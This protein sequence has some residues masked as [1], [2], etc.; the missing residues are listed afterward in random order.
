MPSEKR[1]EQDI[2]LAL[3]KQGTIMFKN[4][5]GTAYRGKLLLTNGKRTLTNPA[6]IRYGLGGIKG[7]SDQIGITP[8]VITSDMIGETI[9]VFT[10]IEV[11]KDKNGKYKATKEQSAFIAMVKANGGIAGVCDS[12]EDSIELIVEQFQF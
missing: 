8:V 4:N 5:V 6:I 7:G 12:V 1:I 2:V 9:G 3:A 10:A 11:K